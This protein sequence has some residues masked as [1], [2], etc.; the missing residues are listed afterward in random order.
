[1]V[2]RARVTSKEAGLRIDAYPA[3]LRLLAAVLASFDHAVA[4]ETKA[5]KPRRARR[6]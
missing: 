2:L 3:V 5:R 1:M 4:D 6:A